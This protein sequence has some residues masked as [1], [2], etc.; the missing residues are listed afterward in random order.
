MRF[1]CTVHSL[2]GTIG[3]A[4]STRLQRFLSDTLKNSRP[5][6]LYPRILRGTFASLISS[7]TTNYAPTTEALKTSLFGSIWRIEKAGI[8]DLWPQP[9]AQETQDLHLCDL[10]SLGFQGCKM[11][12]AALRTMQQI[13]SNAL[14]ISDFIAPVPNRES[15]HSTVHCHRW[16]TALEIARH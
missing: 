13:R 15:E 6:F 16:V 10:V 3:Q 2:I 12:Q 1:V 7:A 11:L 5:A 8:F 4:V 14:R 9:L